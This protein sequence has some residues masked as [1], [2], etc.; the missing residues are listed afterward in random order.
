MSPPA[1]LVTARFQFQVADPV[2]TM[3]PRLVMEKPDPDSVPPLAPARVIRLPG[4]TS[5]LLPPVLIVPPSH[6]KVSPA[7]LKIAPAV[8]MLIVPAFNRTVPPPPPV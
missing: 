1:R 2:W 6:W 4:A 3:E 7:K 5:R 8:P